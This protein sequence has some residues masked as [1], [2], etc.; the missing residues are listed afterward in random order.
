MPAVQSFPPIAAPGATLLILGSM[1]GKASL[2]AQAYYAH[3]RNLFWPLLEQILGI[4]TTQP[5][6]GRCAALTAAGIAVW[7][8]LQTCTRDGSLDA[9]IDPRSIVANDFNT[10][11]AAHPHITRL[12][13]NG[14]A[15]ARIYTRHVLP[16]LPANLAAL[17]R[18]PLPSTSPAN[19]SIPLACKR[20]AWQTAL[21]PVTQS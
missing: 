6:P 5:Y 17:P 20:A 18:L 8:V 21:A 15:A 10:F 12:C 19:A 3:P 16:T 2:Q 13:F 11:F 4:P 7:D 14:S 1:P 9:D